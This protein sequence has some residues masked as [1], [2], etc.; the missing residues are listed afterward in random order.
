MNDARVIP[1]SRAALG[2]LTKAQ[3]DDT[4]P[5]GAYTEASRSR[6]ALE[7]TMGRGPKGESQKALSSAVIARSS[8]SSASSWS[9]PVIR[10]LIAAVSDP[11]TETSV[12]LGVPADF[13]ARCAEYPEL[14]EASR[15]V[16]CW[17]PPPASELR[18]Q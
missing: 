11:D 7:A 2:D 5:P 13:Y 4:T 16:R 17:S 14:V 9:M 6:L 10:G 12:V 8:T 1:R 3:V 18:R 15:T